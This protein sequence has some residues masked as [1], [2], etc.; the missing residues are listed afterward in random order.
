MQ[1]SRDSGVTYISTLANPFPTGLLAP[2]GA[3]GGLATNLGQS[4]Q[5]FDPKLKAAYSQRWSFGLQRSLPGQFVLDVSYVANRSTNI[6]ATRQI[7]AT[8]ER[9]LSTQLVRDQKTIDYVTAQSPNPFSG[10]NPVYSSQISR[11]NL[12]RP[13]PQ[14]GDI[15]MSQPVGYSWYHAMQMRG[16]KRFSQGYT[17]QIGYTYS[18]FMQATEFLNPTDPTPYRVV[19]DMDRPH[20]LTLSGIWELPFG[21]G[22]R[23]GNNL[24]PAANFIL[25]DWQ[26]DGT[27]V[28]Q[29]GSPLAFGN[30][31]FNGNLKDISLPKD[32]RDVDRWFNVDAGF[33]KNSKLQLANNIRT[34]PIRLSGARA[35]GQATWNFSL[36]R[37][38]RISERLNAQF[39]AEAYNAWNHSS[40]DIPNRTPTSSAFGVTTNTLSEPRGFQFALKLAF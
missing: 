36:L 25:R 18:K 16:E 23:F 27:V 32:Q 2:L 22:R 8:P 11:A 14:F 12:L 9:Y 40:F 30:I 39:R 3:R 34:F 1:A 20:V 5:V 26:L 29:A 24:P 6:G 35:D 7:N 4:I 28:R 10:L 15:S 31:I 17:L 33:E 38:F 13:Y 19:S 37:N 21:R